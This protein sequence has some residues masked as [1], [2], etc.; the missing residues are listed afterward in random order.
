MQGIDRLLIEMVTVD[1][2]EKL[3]KLSITTFVN[4]FG[5]QNSPEN[6][7]YYLDKSFSIEQLLLELS[8]ER[9]YFYFASYAGRTIGY[10]KLNIAEKQTDL[11][12]ENGLEIERIYVI[13]D[14][15]GKG[16]G[17]RLVDFSITRA[18]E[19]SKDFVWLGVWDQNFSAI[20]FYKRKGFVES[21]SH[22]FYLGS[23]LQT[24]LV[25]RRSVSL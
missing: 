23:E 14:M 4:T 10:L 9:S 6:I 7:K 11:K 1:S 13:S 25:F 17:G 5:K 20:E 19:F 24:D 22:P 12:E 2:L 18:N 15:Q 3:R 8:A 21:G 16:I